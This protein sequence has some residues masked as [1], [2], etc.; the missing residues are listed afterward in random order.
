M[1]CIVLIG[2]WLKV[3]HYIYEIRRLVILMSSTP[4]V[5][6]SQPVSDVFLRR[7]PEVGPVSDVFL[8]GQ[9]EVGPKTV[10]YEDR[11]KLLLC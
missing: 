2:V 9:P 5:Y 1:S 8:R 10:Q 7:Q 3:V 4:I 6:S 11:W